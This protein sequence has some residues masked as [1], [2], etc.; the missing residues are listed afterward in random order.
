MKRI[1]LILVTLFLLSVPI[2]VYASLMGYWS[3]NETSGTNAYD[4]SGNGNNGTLYNFTGTYWVTGKYG[5]ALK[6]DGVDDFV[7]FGN[8]SSLNFSSDFAIT[9]WVKNYD[10]LLDGYPLDKYDDVNEFGISIYGRTRAGFDLEWSANDDYEYSIDM[11]DGELGGNTYDGDWHFVAIMK[12]STHGILWLDDNSTTVSANVSDINT[13]ADMISGAYY[14]ENSGAL[15]SWYNGTLD[16]LR[17]YDSVLT[18]EEVGN[19][20]LYNSLVAPPEEPEAPTYVGSALVPLIGLV[21]VIGLIGGIITSIKMF[22][23]KEV[24][25]DMIVKAFVGILV[26]LALISFIGV[27]F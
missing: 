8:D 25:M 3:L 15:S 23:E 12:N 17:L 7:N 16:E 14:N 21:M 5:N 1:I 4:I 27:L 18:D 24:D 2:P 19:L 6:F 9:F 22:T 26:L 10:T 20:Y 11:N 13:V